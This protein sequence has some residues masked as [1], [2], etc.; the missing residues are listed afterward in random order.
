MSVRPLRLWDGLAWDGIA[1]LS[2]SKFVIPL[3][4]LGCE[5]GQ[6]GRAL[7]GLAA[8]AR[9]LGDGARPTADGRAV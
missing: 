1:G 3:K 8:F 7:E 2:T 6:A 5:M 9:T 4:L